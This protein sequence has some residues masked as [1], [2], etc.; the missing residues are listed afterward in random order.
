MKPAS[1]LDGIRNLRLWLTPGMKVKRHVGLAMLGAC[2]LILGVVFG[3]LWLSEYS[4]I[5]PSERLESFLLSGRWHRWGGWLSLSG[6]IFGLTLAILAVRRL[7]LSLLSH[8]LARPGD[9]A[10]VLHRQLSLAKGPVIVGLGGGSGLS[11]L[12]RGLR[13]HSSNITAVVTVSDDGGS[14]GRL[15]DAFDMPAPGD[16]TDC[17]AALSDDESALSRLLEYRFGRGGELA[18]HTFGNLLITTLTEVE[19][20]FSQAIRR[21]N[22]ILNICGAVYPGSDETVSLTVVKRS[23]E[24]V[25][26]ES[27]VR[28]VPGAIERAMIEPKNPRAVPEV[29]RAI[30]AADL[31][32]LGPGSLFTSTIPPLLIPETRR[33]L[34][35]G[36]ALIVYVC[37]IMTEAGETDGFSAEDHV[38]ALYKHLGRYPDW[39][40]LNSSP[41]DAERLE[42]YKQEN[43]EVVN[44]N[45]DY[46][47]AKGIQLAELELLGTGPHAQHDS[48]KLAEWLTE[49]A[50]LAARAKSHQLEQIP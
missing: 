22:A 43:A 33:A 29:T 48:V 36:Q 49:Q 13:L 34:H 21:L 42:R 1:S 44:F 19:G 47:K 15:R 45:R 39:V 37:N 35:R 24:E 32:V 2:L 12:L 14:S 41:I 30:Y 16:L 6:V 46:F 27:K 11:N 31:I 9:A 8:W 25:S 40:V 23:G 5:R 3:V 26:G 7:N 10:V 17:L 38:E 18:G 50:K 20:D 4:Q 28:G